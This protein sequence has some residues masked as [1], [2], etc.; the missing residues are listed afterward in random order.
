MLHAD[1]DALACSR[2]EAA[3]LREENGALCAQFAS[4]LSPVSVMCRTRPLESFKDH[5]GVRSALILEGNDLM[6]EGAQRRKFRVD[7]VLDG[8]ASQVDVFTAAAPWVENVALGGSSC[9]FAY[10]ATGA[11]KTH[12]VLGGGA[13][14]GLAH[15]AL[16][17]L[18]EGPKGGEVR[19]S[20]L[21]VY[22]EQ[23]RDLLSE[24]GAAE[25]GAGLPIAAGL[26]APA[27]VHC[28]KRDAQGRVV[29][30]C[31]ELAASTFVKAEQI[32]RRGFAQRATEGTRCNGSSSRSHVVLTVKARGAGAATMEGR[33]VLVDLAG[34]E[35]I[36]RSGADEGGQLLAEA[37]AI[38]KS[39]SALAGVVEAIAKQQSFVPY[40][41]T[42]LT[43]LLE[44]P[45]SV[46]KVLF[47]VHVSPL[48]CDATDTANSLQFGSR[49]QAIDFGAQRM[50]QDQEERLKA[51]QLR[52]Q[53]ENRQLQVELEKVRKERDDEKKAHQES[54]QQAQ[55]E[56]Q[57]RQ[58][59]ADTAETQR[60]RQQVAQLQ[61]QLR[62][63]GK[64]QDAH[65][66]ST[67]SPPPSHLLP[68]RPHLN[69]QRRSGMCPPT[70][71]RRTSSSDAVRPVR[72]STPDVEGAKR[73]RDAT[74]DADAAAVAVAP[75]QAR[76]RMPLGDLTNSAVEQ[77][78][79]AAKTISSP[80][81]L[82]QQSPQKIDASK[83]SPTKT[84]AAGIENFLL[85]ASSAPEIVKSPTRSPAKSP[86]AAAEAAGGPEPPEE[87]EDDAAQYNTYD[88]VT[89]RSCLRQL[90]D[91]NKHR[92]RCLR[93]ERSERPR[94][95]I[96]EETPV[97]Q[98]PPQWYMDR[99]NELLEAERK[100]LALQQYLP[101]TE[102]EAQLAQA[103]R[104]AGT[105]RTRQVTP[106]PRKREVNNENRE[107]R[108]ENRLESTPRWR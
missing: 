62:A 34:S 97:P 38:N 48:M 58:S 32:L 107:N 68:P 103:P 2:A 49:V 86:I 31:V 4:V 17:R 84:A 85:R 60:L 90:T 99:Y 45:L 51:A 91:W 27:A 71:T 83:L 35:N 11:G 23:I 1:I 95:R 21:E 39:L 44:E 65:V 61:E 59:L 74:P 29:L 25:A 7:R 47:L 40:R 57:R 41:D 15:H 22:C 77:P 42:K 80:L 89:V 10:G 26:N 28:S 6:V 52:S 33:L 104:L 88:G 72:D 55:R 108:C 50:R 79:G 66:R 92:Q 16:Q 24:P 43:T 78:S 69:R 53:Q 75:S 105:P 14:F 81:K 87:N 73:V 20:M 101:A 102:E 5:S 93:Q 94:V 100:G 9:V 13:T 82:T 36:Q 8:K 96:S 70:P 37:K 12:T 98:P 18:I 64:D 63:A 106:P 46:S 19:V 76:G 56:A 67:T 3:K 54:R 30:D